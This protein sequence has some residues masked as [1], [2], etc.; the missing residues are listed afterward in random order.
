M[1]CDAVLELIKSH[2]E[3]VVYS[4]VFGLLLL[5]QDNSECVKLFA[6]LFDPSKFSLVDTKFR[7]LCLSLFIPLLENVPAAVNPGFIAVMEK[8]LTQA[9]VKICRLLTLAS[10]VCS[11]PKL[12]VPVFGLFENRAN[13]FLRAGAEPAL[14]A[15]LCKIYVK[16][17]VF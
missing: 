9:P 2:D 12:I 1:F 6:Q 16:F 13:V 10:N 8:Y 15:Q 7:E 11:D 14:I 4:A 5:L 3:D 17:P